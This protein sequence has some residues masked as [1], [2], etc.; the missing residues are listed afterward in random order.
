MSKNTPSLPRIATVL[1]TAAL[2]GC[3]AGPDYRRPDVAV[4]DAYG[5]AP[6]AVSGDWTTAVPA[7]AVDKGR[8]WEAFGDPLLNGL[9]ARLQIGN[10]NVRA[11]E[12]R[13]RQAQLLSQAARTALFP[14]LSGTLA[15]Q[16]AGGSGR[17]GGTANTFSATLSASWEVDLWGR[18]RRQVEGAEASAQASAADLANARLSAQAA[19]A[20]NYVALRIADA[21]RT[22]LEAESA[23]Y[24]RALQLT[25]NRYAAGVV[26]AADVAQ[27]QTQLHTTQAQAIDVGIQRA[28]LQ[29]AIAVLLGEPPAGFSIEAAP[30]AL[31]QPMIPPGVPSR[32]LERRPDIA[33]AERRV[34]SANAQIG[35]AESAWFPNLTLGA[36]AGAQA[37]TFANLFSAPA[38]LWSVG[39]SL[40]ETLFD[41]G[42]RRLQT[43]QARAA[44]DEAVANY[45]QTVLGG[46]QE[47]EDRL[48]AL[49]ILGAESD[50]QARALE[51]ARRSAALTLNQYKAGTVSYLS[52]VTVQ[53]TALASER[54]SIDLRGQ[55]LTASITLIQ[56][57]GGGWHGVGAAAAQ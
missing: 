6:P 4:P 31:R 2:A 10:N 8:W 33:A 19:L 23:E 52:V 32:L 51:A 45:R 53:A 5:E 46:F 57:L 43:E 21:Q 36:S 20:Q 38:R 47:V 41:A 14:T 54:S 17:V 22:L 34:A 12:A 13:Y 26:S 42:L 37:A 25:Q 7:D 49:R 27:A 15:G 40:V 16:R 1:V 56:A 29:H 28:Q 11:A 50:E 44:Y 48:A 55:R 9:E 30:L 24:A 18:V 35:V 3:A 39:P